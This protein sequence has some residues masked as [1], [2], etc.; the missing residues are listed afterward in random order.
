MPHREGEKEKRD[1]KEK[2]EHE[3]RYKPLLPD[4]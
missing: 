2:N 4:W 3:E 1:R